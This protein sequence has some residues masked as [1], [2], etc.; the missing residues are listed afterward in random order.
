MLKA[1]NMPKRCQKPIPYMETSDSALKT[2]MMHDFAGALKPRDVIIPKR[3]Q[4]PILYM[5]KQVLRCNGVDLIRLIMLE[6]S[7]YA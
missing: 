6:S 5:E 1:R 2:E 7:N 3:C 4:K